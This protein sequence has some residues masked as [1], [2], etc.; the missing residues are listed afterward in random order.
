MPPQKHYL[1]VL[2]LLYSYKTT[3]SAHTLLKITLGTLDTLPSVNSKKGG[4]SLSGAG[5]RK[6]RSDKK[7]DVKPTLSFELKDT[8]Y[9]LSYITYTPV[10]NIGEALCIDAMYNQKIITSL[11]SHFKRNIK[12]GNT[13]YIGN[14]DSNQIPK[15]LPAPTDK[16]TIRFKQAHFDFIYDLAY[17]LNVSP[18]RVVAILLQY[19]MSDMATVNR[20]IVSYLEHE[21]TTNQLKELKEVLRYI[22]QNSQHHH[23]W[24]AFLSAIVD[25]TNG[26]V[27]R[28]KE[29]IT[30]FLS[31]M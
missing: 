21:L 14:R 30:N 10:K 6:I 2:I 4:H 20:F 13:M 28:L 23:S 22:N 16:I 1:Q 3:S 19:A 29:M 12:I 25:E 7:K 9:R 26:T 5:Q 27:T 18:S 15:R 8:I 24:Y 17:A 11:A 31:D